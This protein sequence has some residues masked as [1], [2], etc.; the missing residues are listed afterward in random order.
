MVRILTAHLELTIPRAIS[1]NLSNWTPVQLLRDDVLEFSPSLSLEV[2][3]L[4]VAVEIPSFFYEGIIATS[5]LVV[6][7]LRQDLFYT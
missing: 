1:L 6:M 2:R 3:T 4:R 5:E 7:D